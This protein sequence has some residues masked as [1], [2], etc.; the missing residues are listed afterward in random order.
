MG[1]SVHTSSLICMGEKVH[2]QG[3]KQKAR[4]VAESQVTRSEDWPN[5][6]D[7]RTGSQNARSSCGKRGEPFV[8][9]RIIG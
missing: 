3:W 6:G 7:L 9:F 4:K 1:A 5:N 2:L 8:F